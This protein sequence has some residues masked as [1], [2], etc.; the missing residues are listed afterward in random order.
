[1]QKGKAPS[2]PK[3]GTATP[4]KVLFA[5]SKQATKPEQE[6]GQSRGAI[7]KQLNWDRKVL[8]TLVSTFNASWCL[9]AYLFLIG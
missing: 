4:K 5:E 9:L 3:A 7:P 8:D 1:M 2:P 6:E